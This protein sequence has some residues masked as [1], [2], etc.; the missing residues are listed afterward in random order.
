[1]ART[2]QCAKLHK[3][4]EGLDFPPIPGELGKRIYENISKE[5]W[6]GWLKQQTMLINENRLNMADVRARQYLLKQTEK[7]FFGEGADTA[8]GYVPPQG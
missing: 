4:A 1:M 3:E 2:I 5:A 6:Q 8:A 7:Y